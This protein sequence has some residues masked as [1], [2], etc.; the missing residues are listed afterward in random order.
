MSQSYPHWLGCRLF[1]VCCGQQGFFKLSRW[2]YKVQLRWK[3]IGS[4]VLETWFPDKQHWHHLSTC[5]ECKFKGSIPD[6]P[7]QKLWVGTSRWV[8]TSLTAM[9]IQVLKLENLWQ[10]EMVWQLSPLKGFLPLSQ[11]CYPG[12]SGGWNSFTLQLYSGAREGWSGWHWVSYCPA[13]MRECNLNKSTSTQS[14]FKKKRSSPLSEQSKHHSK[15]GDGEAEIRRGAS[16]GS[17]ESWRR[18]ILVV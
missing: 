2:F 14:Q 9:L 17:G 4:L 11:T 8:L 3:T 16:R 13:K 1:G 12:N 7:N 5:K 15:H 18:G 10:R 6:L